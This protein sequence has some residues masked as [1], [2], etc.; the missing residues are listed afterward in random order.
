MICQKHSI[1]LLCIKDRTESVEHYPRIP[2]NFFV[3][4]NL[5]HLEQEPSTNIYLPDRNQILRY[6]GEME[7]MVALAF[8]PLL[9]L[10]S[11]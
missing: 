2:F 1:N 3:C 6:C 5:Y 4:D 8:F 9:T 7:K 10:I 11:S